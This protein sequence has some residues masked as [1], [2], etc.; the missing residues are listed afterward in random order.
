MSEL[1][2]RP[3]GARGLVTEV[4]PESAGWA[5]VGF[6]LH[7]LGAGESLAAADGRARGLSGAGLGQGEAF[8]RRQGFWR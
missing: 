5:Y 6:A 8:D 3:K 4:T 2:V 1:R 7:R